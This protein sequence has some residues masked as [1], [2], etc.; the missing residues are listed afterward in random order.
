MDIWKL[1]LNNNEVVG[2]IGEFYT[3]IGLTFANLF[4]YKGRSIK[5][6]YLPKTNGN[7]TELDM[8]Y[9]TKKGIFVFESKNYSGWIFGNENDREWTASLANGNKNRFYNP[10]LQNKTHIET[11]QGLIGKGIPLFSI[12]VFSDRCTL[13]K[14]V[15][16]QSQVKVINRI[17]LVNTIKD[18]WNKSNDLLSDNNIDEIYN[19]LIKYANADK[20][21]KEKHI[22]NI[23]KRENICPKCGANLMIRTAKSGANVGKQF[24][25]CSRFPSCRY[26]RNF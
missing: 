20:T 11:L 4:G 15:V 18:I 16:N 21:V 10:V 8:I 23:K 3:G 7:T 26:T 6:L 25:G 24:Y 1:I 5:N 17:E 2:E 13:K 9:I 22:D 12:I 14:I 19:D